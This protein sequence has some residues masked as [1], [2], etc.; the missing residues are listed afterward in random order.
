MGNY[1]TLSLGLVFVLIPLPVEW[2]VIGPDAIALIL[3]Y[4]VIALP[5][6]VG[7]L[8]RFVLVCYRT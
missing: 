7:I 1:V 4:W 8:R 6:R 2:R 5:H 3:F